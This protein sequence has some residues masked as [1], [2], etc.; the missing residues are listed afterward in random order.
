[1]G[2]FERLKQGL[3]KTREGLVS[4]LDDVFSFHQ[5]VDDDLFEELEEVLI[6]SDISVEVVME[7]LEKLRERADKER[8]AE[9][10]QL[11]D[12]LKEELLKFLPTE[13]GLQL[14]DGLNVILV[15]G[16]NGVGKTTTIG[17]LAHLLKKQ[18]HRVI[19]AAADTFR[20]AAADQLTVWANRVGVEIIKH[21][22]GADPSA[23]V[24]DT[25][26]AARARKADVVVVDT[27]GRLHN[28]KNL[29]NEVAKIRRVIAREVPGAPQETLLVVDAT[30]GQNGLHQAQA[31][32]EAVDL[33]G[34]VLTKLDGT[35][36]GGIV[37]SIAH[38]FSLPVKFVGV[39][40]KLDDLQ[41]FAAQEFVAALFDK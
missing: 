2:L 7:I 13:A 37:L 32:H 28:K 26:Q 31:F 12:L 22:P 24:Y 20:A 16:V 9:S 30:T 33:S 40:E 8:I 19:L 41:P 11:Y 35:A 27:A 5:T 3:R 14:G 10:A 38:D 39:G 23:V 1:M 17:K 18:G 29:M 6:T 21:Q 36:K 4:K 34:I 25:I 15:V